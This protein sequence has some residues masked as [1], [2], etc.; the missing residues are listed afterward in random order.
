M[1]ETSPPASYGDRC[2]RA[3]L[4]RSDRITAASAREEVRLQFFYR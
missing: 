1:P 4:L 2:H 3:V